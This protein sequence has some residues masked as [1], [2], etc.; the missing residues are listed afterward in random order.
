MNPIRVALWGYGA[1]GQG[2]A[3]LVAERPGMELVAVVVRDKR[4]V[5][6]PVPGDPLLTT[7]PEEMFAR[8]PDVVLLSTTSFV[9]DV[10]TI[11]LR[12]V[13]H[14]VHVIT[15]AEEMSA[16]AAADPAAA[17]RLHEAA[18][19]HG[20][21]VLG[22][23]VNPGFVMDLLVVALTGVCHRVEHIEVQRI[24]DLSPYG[25]TVL[26]TQ[27]VGTTPEEFA[28]GLK[29]GAIVGHVGFRQSMHLIASA[30]GWELERVQ[31]EREP[32]V[33]RVRRQTPYIVVEPGQVAGCRHT[34]TG[35][36]HGREVV[37]LV[38]PQQ[39]RPEAEN[40]E[41]QDFIHIQGVP[42]IRLQIR[43]EIAG[44]LAT[45]ALAVNMIPLLMAAKPGLHH[46]TDLPVPR[47][48]LG[49]AGEILRS[50]RPA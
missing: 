23:G 27:G 50:L 26:R 4:R 45:E 7:D 41:T 35:W 13:S 48:V 37:R 14:G 25:P 28:A 40:V 11:I 33:T 38:H 21:G 8:R 29:S 32:I 10:E 43:P 16:P 15:I 20:V 44:G 12:I 46:M 9:R 42:E 47:A 1:M 49:D 30:L 17:K 34:A 31:E 3:R 6:Q 2:V 22:T 18:A 36:R 39:I 24:N 19:A 5:P